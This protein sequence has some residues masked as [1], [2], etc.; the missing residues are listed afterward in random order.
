MIHR[1]IF[2][3]DMK[4]ILKINW[5]QELQGLLDVFSQK[6]KIEIKYVVVLTGISRIAGEKRNL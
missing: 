4:R 5:T 3:Y 2:L 1:D 6:V